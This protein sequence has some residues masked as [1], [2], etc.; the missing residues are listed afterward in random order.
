M[1]HGTGIRHSEAKEVVIGGHGHLGLGLDVAKL[2]V[3]TSLGVLAFE[4]NTPIEVEE[5]ATTEGALHLTMEVFH[6]GP[7]VVDRGREGDEVARI[8]LENVLLPVGEGEHH[9]IMLQKRSKV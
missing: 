5:H 6:G 4:I 1:K 3:H 7:L 2:V 8:A 9:A